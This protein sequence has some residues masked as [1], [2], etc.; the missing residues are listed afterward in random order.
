MLR[1]IVGRCHFVTSPK[2]GIEVVPQ[3]TILVLTALP[4][5][6]PETASATPSPR[7]R[8]RPTPSWPL[9]TPPRSTAVQVQDDALGKYVVR[10]ALAYERDG[11]SGVIKAARNCGDMRPTLPGSSHPAIRLL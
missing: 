10:M 5:T 8:K 1:A 2:L 9:A 7:K 6:P 11:W 3:H 4:N